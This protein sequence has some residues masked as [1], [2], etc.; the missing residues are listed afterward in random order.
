MRSFMNKLEKKLGKI[1]SIDEM[2]VV[3]SLKQ[4]LVSSEINFK[5][6]FNSGHVPQ[7]LYDLDSF[8]I[9]FVNDA[10][11]K[12]YGYSAEEF[13]NMTI[14][15][16]APQ[17]EIQKLVLYTEF[18]KTT[19]E[20]FSVINFNRKKNDESVLVESTY[21]NIK[22]NGLPTVLVTSKDIAEKIKHEEKIS[23][24]K[25]TRQQ[26]ITLATINGQERERDQLGKELNENINQLL[27]SAKLYLGLSRSNKQSRID[28]IDEA[29]KYLIKAIKEIRSLSTSLVPATLEL[30]GFKGSLDQ[31]CET[32]VENEIL[33]I[34]LSLE[35]ELD[36]LDKEIQISLFRIIQEQLKNVLKHAEAHNV[37]I[38][39]CVSDQIRLSIKDDGKGF[40]TSIQRTGSGISNMINR[41]GLFEG[42]VKILSEPEKGFTLLI[43]IPGEKN[44]KSK[45]YSSVIIV[46][47]DPD[48]L[49]VLT[50][51]FGEI[52][53]HYN[54]TCLND[55]KMLVDLLQ[56]FP[57]IE[58]PSLIILDYNMPLLNGLETLKVLELDHR[59]NKIPKIIYS[60]SSQNYIKNLCYSA[61]A[62]AYITKGVTMDEIKE[63]ILEMMTFV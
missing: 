50:R 2:I 61:N 20:P 58:L 45:G 60:S 21:V 25:V 38:S 23:L 17:E 43:S 19:N 53:P 27:A 1:E 7:W 62:K 15:E 9:L 54:I 41:V 57:D 16:I 59:F 46:E 48:D 44:N 33:N 31:L 37:L 28:F 32:Y 40:D 10:A 8:R 3:K 5:H 36:N 18:M 12:E 63:N 47:D 55:G 49:E 13:L 29:E 22:F 14:L 26:K 6:L 4:A 35:G 30:I 51:V 42:T 34:H 11:I 56:S 52:A 39:L 24:L